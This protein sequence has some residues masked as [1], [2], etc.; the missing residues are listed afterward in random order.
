MANQEIKI[1]AAGGFS[2]SIIIDYGT[3]TKVVRGISV[4]D[5]D[6][7]I[8]RF[9]YNSYSTSKDFY[10]FLSDGNQHVI[11]SDIKKKAVKELRFDGT[12]FFAKYKSTFDGLYAGYEFFIPAKAINIEFVAR[13]RYEISNSIGVTTIYH[14]DFGRVEWLD[15]Y[16]DSERKRSLYEKCEALRRS[17][18]M[19]EYYICD[20]KKADK[21]ISIIEEYSTKM[22]E[23]AK[24][25]AIPFNMTDEQLFDAVPIASNGCGRACQITELELD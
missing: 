21:T 20:P 24:E 2:S 11:N 16:S 7:V 10:S 14:S 18:D 23:L 8:A 13:K 25:A 6:T 3:S 15:F 12:A 9:D 5:G 22:A 19:A 1:Y 17:L 4:Y